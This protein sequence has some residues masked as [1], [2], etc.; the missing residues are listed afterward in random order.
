[1]ITLLLHT[2]IYLLKNIEVT[3]QIYKDYA[4]ISVVKNH[5]YWSICFSDCKY[6]EE[7]TAMAFEN[8]LIGM[9]N[10]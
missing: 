5:E 9:E 2:D 8:Y 4:D 10:A 1:M 7:L 3:K 6:D